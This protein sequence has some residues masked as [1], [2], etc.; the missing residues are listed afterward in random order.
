MKTAIAI[1]LTCLVMAASAQTN[2]IIK[3]NLPTTLQYDGA[4][5][6]SRY[7]TNSKP[8][9]LMVRWTNPGASGKPE[10]FVMHLRNY[11]YVRSEWAVQE[12]QHP[13]GKSVEWYPIKPIAGNAR[14]IS[15][16]ATYDLRGEPTGHELVY[17]WVTNAITK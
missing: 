17:E 8:I 5:G 16:T 11:P 10:L 12:T 1:L 14:Q 15:V 2:K 9:V 7:E 6:G 3:I 13:Y 4:G